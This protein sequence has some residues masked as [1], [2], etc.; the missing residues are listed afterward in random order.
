[1]LEHKIGI[2]FS[3]YCNRKWI[4]EVH[5][6]ENIPSSGFIV[7]S[8]HTSYLDIWILQA[9]FLLNKDRWVKFLAKKELMK[10]PYFRITTFLMG[11]DDNMP[12]LI[13]REHADST[14][15]FEEAL[16]SLHKGHI[17]GVFPEGGRSKTGL[18]REGKTGMIRLA[19]AAKVPI[20]PIGIQGTFDLMPPGR[21][22][23]K[24]ERKCILKIG[25]PIDLSLHYN[26]ELSK[27]TLKILT[28]K[29][30]REIAEL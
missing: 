6:L 14:N 17:I 8:N 13:D 1:M 28:T 15:Y 29:A 24:N 25:K 3:R 5:G 23:P 21:K 2:T 19:L 9:T 30:M 16:A 7:A 26:K 4:K 18:L 27:G 22:L 12:I 20:L 10:D 11:K